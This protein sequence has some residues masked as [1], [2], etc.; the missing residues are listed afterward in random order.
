LLQ[1]LSIV[2]NFVDVEHDLILDEFVFLLLL[3]LDLLEVPAVVDILME[4]VR[5]HV[6]LLVV[7][8]RVIHLCPGGAVLVLHVLTLLLEFHVVP[9][10]KMGVE[11]LP[12]VM[13]GFF[14]N[15][16]YLVLFDLGVSG[17]LLFR[18]LGACIFQV[19]NVALQQFL[20][21]E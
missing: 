8:M 1:D 21:A 4:D 10:R 3:F 19:E 11:L 12:F 18:H 2:H 9:D 14:L 6:I 16:E 20:L 17:N 7:F 15:V 13:N 5:L